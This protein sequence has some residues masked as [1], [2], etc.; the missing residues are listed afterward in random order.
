VALLTFEDRDALDR[1]L[2]ADKRATAL[3]AM[4]ELAEGERTLT[5]LGDFAGWFSGPAPHPR[6]WKQALVVLAALIPVALLAALARRQ[7]APELPLALS[8]ML[9]SA[10]NVALLTWVVMPGLTR[11]LDGWLSR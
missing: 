9:T 4:A 10:W 6:R 2:G 7:L 8:V 3:D 5:V 1:W 11:G